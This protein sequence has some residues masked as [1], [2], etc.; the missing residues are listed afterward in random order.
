M[1]IENIRYKV[2]SRD[3]DHP[4]KI[5][6]TG[7]DFELV[8]HKLGGVNKETA[9]IRPQYVRTLGHYC[10]VTGLGKIG[11]MEKFLR[12]IVEYETEKNYPPDTPIGDLTLKKITEKI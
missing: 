5:P 9:L 8:V 12:A 3:K 11:N 10:S 6:T 2:L 1:T 4:E 7:E